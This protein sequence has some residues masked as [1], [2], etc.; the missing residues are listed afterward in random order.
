MSSRT[1]THS[2]FHIEHAYPAAPA[3][4]FAAFADA[5]V[6]RRWF[7]ESEGFI[8]D[9][10]E[11]DFA[12]GGEEHARFR[13]APG[14]PLPAGTTCENHTRYFD[15][16]PDRRIVI[17]YSMTVGGSRIS[18]SLATFEFLE[19]K[20]GTR[21]FFTEQAAFFENAD[22]PELREKGWRD[23]LDRLATEIGG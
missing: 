16:V 18:A 13:F 9:A 23:L 2:T 7:A 15:I 12:I 22:G 6:K 5:G 10:F 21:L 14:S 1:T 11:M 19:V 8:V 20:A 4:V 3:K 17:A